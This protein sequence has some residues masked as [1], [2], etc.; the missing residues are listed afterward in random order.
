[1]PAQSLGKPEAG[2]QHPVRFIGRH[3]PSDLP[4]RY[5]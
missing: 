5:F 4:G 1:V 2:D 3:G